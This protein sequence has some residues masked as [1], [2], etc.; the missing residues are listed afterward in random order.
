MGNIVFQHP[1]N[2]L[3]LLAARTSLTIVKYR[4]YY[5]PHYASACAWHGEA[6]ISGYNL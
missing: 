2:A 4:F 6:D 3:E 1:A 5:V